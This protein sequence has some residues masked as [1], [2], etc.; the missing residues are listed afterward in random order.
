ME[1]RGEF[2]LTL[3]SS[4]LGGLASLVAGEPLGLVSITKV[5]DFLALASL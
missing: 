4:V 1:V 3:S 2:T 5:P